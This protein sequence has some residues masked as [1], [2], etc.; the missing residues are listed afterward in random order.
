MTALSHPT[1]FIR[2][3]FVGLT[4]ALLVALAF[5]S[6][7]MA[8][9]P[10]PPPPLPAAP[11]AVPA[12]GMP[13]SDMPPAPY[14][15]S[16]AAY[17]TV[18]PGENLFRI[19]LKY[20]LS[21]VVLQQVN[22]LPSANFVVVGQVLC[23]PVI[24]PPITP[25]PP[26]TG[27][28]PTLPPPPTIFP[29]TA[30][31]GTGIVLPPPGVYP[32]IDIQPRYAKPGTTVTITGVNFPTNEPSDILITPLYSYQPYVPVASLT[33]TATGTVNTSFVIPTTVNGQPL[34]GAAFS[35]MVKGKVTG[36]F[37]Y[38]YVYNR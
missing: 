25:P 18:A 10:Q 37:G 36:Y 29:P 19:G 4:A 9:T 22:H 35:I 21:W 38:N 34:T 27:I 30:V 1:L 6:P 2:R 14:Q 11:V 31:P 12:P 26:P 8:Q 5:T 13:A 20:G 15:Y 24:L 28:P 17:H 16:C 33:T 23:I 3:V 7:A 32:K